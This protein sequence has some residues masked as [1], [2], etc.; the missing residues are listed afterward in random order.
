MVTPVNSCFQLNIAQLFDESRAVLVNNTASL[1][2]ETLI[3]GMSYRKSFS[4]QRAIQDNRF[5]EIV[6]FDGRNE[7]AYISRLLA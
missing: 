5:E 3:F 7:E 1:K 2:V 6:F 4:G